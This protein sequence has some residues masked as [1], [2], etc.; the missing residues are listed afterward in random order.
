LR[1]YAQVDPK[2]E[3]KAEGYRM[4]E[5]LLASIADGVTDKVFRVHIPTPEEEE[6]RLQEERRRADAQRVFEAANAAG[7]VAQQA[8]QLA[9]AVYSGQIPAD[10]AVELIKEAEQRATSGGGASG[11]G[12]DQN[13]GA[14]ISLLPKTPPGATARPP[15]T[16]TRSVPARGAFDLFKQAEQQRIAAERAGQMA[17]GGGARPAAK[18]DPA[19]QV[20]R[21]DPCPCGSGKKFKVCHG[22]AA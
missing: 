19:K 7:V 14:G 21:N 2:N 15:V 1:S 13:G 4:F 18:S 12:E 10:K 22:K 6:A 16:P 3:Y 17:G 8:Q 5:E 11:G 20:G 9:Q